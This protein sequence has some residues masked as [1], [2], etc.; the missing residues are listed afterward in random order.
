MRFA[1][2]IIRGDDTIVSIGRAECVKAH[3]TQSD[4]RLLV[5]RINV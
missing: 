5:G 4:S 1:T 2:V 3:R